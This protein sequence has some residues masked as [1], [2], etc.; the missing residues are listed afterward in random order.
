MIRGHMVIIH[1]IIFFKVGRNLG[2]LKTYDFSINIV[3]YNI[4]EIIHY[5]SDLDLVL[6]LVLFRLIQ[7]NF[8]NY[9]FQ[10]DYFYQV[11]Y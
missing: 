4:S 2:L 5:Y 7:H 11:L 6:V 8:H 10:D 9:Y 1:I 3:E